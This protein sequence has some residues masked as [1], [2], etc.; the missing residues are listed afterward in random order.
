MLIDLRGADTLGRSEANALSRPNAL[1][2]YVDVLARSFPGQSSFHD[3]VSA[4]ILRIHNTKKLG[5]PIASAV[6]P[7]LDGADGRPADLGCLLVADPSGDQQHGFTL[8]DGKL[9]Q[10]GP[11]VLNVEVAILCRCCGELGSVN[12]F[13]V[14]DLSSSPAIRG[15]ELIARNRKQPCR[16][17]RAGRELVNIPECAHHSLLDQVIRLV[18]VACKRDRKSAEAWED[19]QDV[20]LKISGH[21]S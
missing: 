18:D 15:V 13:R 21:A 19:A 17:V 12:S 5:Q 6:D 20:P 8:F 1:G 14:F 2:R 3:T 4:N 9:D 16:H 10:S 11:E 7:T